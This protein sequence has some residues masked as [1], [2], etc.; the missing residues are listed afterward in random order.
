MNKVDYWVS[1]E[2]WDESQKSI[3][4]MLIHTNN[5]NVGTGGVMSRNWI[6]QKLQTGY[7]F[8][9]IYRTEGRKWTIGSQLRL[10]SGSLKWDDTLPLIQ[11]KR[12]T[13]ISY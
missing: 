8:K 5:G 3:V 9:C 13:F 4:S 2:K 12:K 7:I 11:T 1:K 10:E 6:V